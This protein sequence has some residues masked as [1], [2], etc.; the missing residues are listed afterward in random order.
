MSQ[1]WPATAFCL[2]RARLLG[3]LFHGTGGD[4]LGELALEDDEE[5]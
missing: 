5:D 3:V 4:A 2:G 1:A